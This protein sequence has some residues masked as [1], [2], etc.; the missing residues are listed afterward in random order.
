MKPKI[1]A[2]RREEL[3]VVL[4]LLER[5]DLP[6]DGVHEH[7]AGFLVAESQGQILGT[8][9]LEIYDSVGLLRSLAVEPAEQGSG[10]GARLVE[11]VLDE[12]RE[13]NLEAVYLLTTTADRYFPRFGFERLAREEVDPRLDASKELQG[14][15][16][17]TA[18]CMR[19]IL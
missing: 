6:P 8:V 16:P 18:F 17:Q 11:S 13:K 15:C 2:A 9:G 12:A 3:E 14:A 19:L 5:S 10:L 1:R 7:L 4:S